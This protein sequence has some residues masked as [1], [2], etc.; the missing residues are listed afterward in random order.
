MRS[1]GGMRYWLPVLVVLTLG[2]CA[3][4]NENVSCRLEVDNLQERNRAL[5]SALQQVE[6][7]GGAQGAIARAALEQAKH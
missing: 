6:A 2:S 1:E 4:V 5:V 7:Q 3:L